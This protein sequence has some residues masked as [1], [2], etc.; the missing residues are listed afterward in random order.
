MDRPLWGESEASASS[1]VGGGVEL[2][3]NRSGRPPRVPKINKVHLYSLQEKTFEQLAQRL[4]L[5]HC[6]VY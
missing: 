4:L 5:A 3:G 6:I 1:N 2:S